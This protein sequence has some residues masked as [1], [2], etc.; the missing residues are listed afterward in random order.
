MTIAAPD[1]AHAGTDSPALR[2][3][4][5]PAMLIAAMTAMRLVYAGVTDLRTD[6]AYY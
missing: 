1:K 2:K 5:A 6:E 4:L 3:L